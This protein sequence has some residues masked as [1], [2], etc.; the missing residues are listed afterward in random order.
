[1]E[2]V[3][4]VLSIIITLGVIYGMG[5]LVYNHKQLIRAYKESDFLAGIHFIMGLNIAILIWIMLIAF[6]N[7]F[8]YLIYLFA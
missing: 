7:T 5:R 1:M 8:W 4:A 6:N 3:F 2:I